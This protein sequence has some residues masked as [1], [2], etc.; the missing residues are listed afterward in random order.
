MV[1]GSIFKYGSSFLIRTLKP[2][3]CN[4]YASEAE[5]RPFP[6]DET[7]PPVTKIYRVMEICYT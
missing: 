1:P 7:T 3:D 6:S 4:K 5:E 2:L